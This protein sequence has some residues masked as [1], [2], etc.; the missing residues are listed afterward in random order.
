MVKKASKAPEGVYDPWAMWL[1]AQPTEEER[2]AMQAVMDAE[3]AR[4]RASGVY[5]RLP[6][7]RGN[8]KFS[9]TYEEM[10]DK[11]DDRHDPSSSRSS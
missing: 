7:L 2:A 3:M 5:E 4:A 1:A 11:V 6:N 10:V 8:V 9:L